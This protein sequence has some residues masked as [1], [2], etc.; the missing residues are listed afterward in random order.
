MS[1]TGTWRLKQTW[2]DENGPPNPRRDESPADSGDHADATGYGFKV[3][4]EADGRVKAFGFLFY[5][6][7]TEAADGGVNFAMTDFVGQTLTLYQ[8]TADA[9]GGYSGTAQGLTHL[10][11]RVHQGTWT[12][13]RVA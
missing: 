7:W 8:G 1:F 9:G 12:A 11:G 2:N 6:T 10:L 3:E 13:T 5:G 4:F